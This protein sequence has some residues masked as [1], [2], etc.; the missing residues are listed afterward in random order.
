MSPCKAATAP[1]VCSVGEIIFQQKAFVFSLCLL[2]IR[3]IAQ[4]GESNL[5]PSQWNSPASS[6]ESSP[7]GH[8]APFVPHH[9][10]V[11]RKSGCR[12]QVPAGDIFHMV[13]KPQGTKD[14]CLHAI[15]E[16]W[17]MSFNQFCF[18]VGKTSSMTL[19]IR[20]SKSCVLSGLR[21]ILSNLEQTS[22]RLTRTSLHS[23]GKFSFI[24]ARSPTSLIKMINHFLSCHHHN[25]AG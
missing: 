22:M 23:I 2:K 12:C 4:R 15:A 7:G 16:G 25:Y 19:K 17:V 6:T 11:G 8:S 3:G 5:R 24:P 10:F 9:M 14:A 13:A 20:S 18:R 21:M 1:T